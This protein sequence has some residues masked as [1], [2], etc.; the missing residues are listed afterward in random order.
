MIW[1][2]LNRNKAFSL[3]ISTVFQIQLL[4]SIKCIQMHHPCGNQQDTNSIS[5]IRDKKLSRTR[6]PLNL[7]K[8]ILGHALWGG[9]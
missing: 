8:L 6:C 3:T 7:L 9:G 4:I 5:Q 1:T 2:I